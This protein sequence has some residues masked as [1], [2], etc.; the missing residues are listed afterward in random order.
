VGNYGFYR[1]AVGSSYPIPVSHS[2]IPKFLDNISR[3]T[4]W[5]TL[6]FDGKR[7]G[8]LIFITNS[9]VT[10]KPEDGEAYGDMQV[11]WYDIATGGLF[12]EVYPSSCGV[13]SALDYQ[14]EVTPD[15]YQP[16]P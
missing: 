14:P 3:E 4:H 2:R 5:I 15:W 6:A 8:V 7:N 10:A 13:F 12:P 11:Y 9:D 1:A 16:V